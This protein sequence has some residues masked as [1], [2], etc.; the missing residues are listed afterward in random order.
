M[1]R[2]EPS[3]AQ[4]VAAARV[5]VRLAAAVAGVRRV[6]GRVIGAPDYEAYV[7]HAN[8]RHPERVMTRQE[9]HDARLT[10]R[11]EKPGSRCC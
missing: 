9:F 7:A 3:V 10:E 4:A 5:A 11:Y 1:G 6:V 2:G 8:A